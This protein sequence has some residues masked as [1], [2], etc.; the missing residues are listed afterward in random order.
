MAGTPIF[1]QSFLN[2]L[3]FRSRYPDLLVR[4]VGAFLL[5]TL[6]DLHQVGVLHG[7]IKPSNIIKYAEKNGQL[8]DRFCLIDFSHAKV[9]GPNGWPVLI[10][11]AHGT[12]PFMSTGAMIGDPLTPLDD[13]ESL[14]YTLFY[15][16]LGSLPWTNYEKNLHDILLGNIIMA[17]KMNFSWCQE[18]ISNAKKLD[19]PLLQM[20][21][22]YLPSF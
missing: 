21:F 1:T 10:G 17:G 7:D 5:L 12:L 11:G 22:S 6:R 2:F 3:R 20:H 9:V 15:L 19:I 13:L 8:Q 18:C 4:K 14:A 16:V